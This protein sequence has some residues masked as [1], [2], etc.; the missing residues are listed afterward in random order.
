MVLTERYLE[1][2]YD[3]LLQEQL[4]ILQDIKSGSSEHKSTSEHKQI[5]LLTTLLSGVLKL[6]DLKRKETM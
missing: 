1:E 6:R 5:S 2:M 4:R 3:T